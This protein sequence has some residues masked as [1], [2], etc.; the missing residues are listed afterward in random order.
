MK[1][2][3]LIINQKVYAEYVTE[4]EIIYLKTREKLN[5]CT[6]VK[7]EDIII[8]IISSIENKLFSH[9]AYLNIP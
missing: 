3:K 8:Q 5:F 1:T 7:S 4:D 9:A 6:P 2:K